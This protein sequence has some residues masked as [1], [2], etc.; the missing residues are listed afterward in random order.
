MMV[1][2]QISLERSNKAMQV[3][4]LNSLQC[5]HS[6]IQAEG[7]AMIRLMHACD[8]EMALPLIDMYGKFCI[9]YLVVLYEVN[10]IYYL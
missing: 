8:A 4:Q 2:E 1:V 6:V 10:T 7:K 5:Q 9:Q 3:S